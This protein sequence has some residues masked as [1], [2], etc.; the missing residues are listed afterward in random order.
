[1]AVKVTF[2]YQTKTVVKSTCVSHPEMYRSNERVYSPMA[3]KTDRQTKHFQTE[4][5]TQNP[6]VL[7]TGICTELSC[8]QY[9]TSQVLVPVPVLEVG[10]MFLLKTVNVEVNSALLLTSE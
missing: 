2:G 1:M 9:T 5:Q 7:T 10:I 4:T 6:Q 8:S 3:K